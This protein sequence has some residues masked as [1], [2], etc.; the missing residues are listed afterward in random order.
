M[1]RQRLSS[2]LL[3][4][5]KLLRLHAFQHLLEWLSLFI[6]LQ[7][8]SPILPVNPPRPRGSPGLPQSACFQCHCSLPL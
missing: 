4:P 8:P 1:Y 5:R 7:I 3:V 6:P 2:E